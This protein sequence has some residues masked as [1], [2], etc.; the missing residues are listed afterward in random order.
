[1]ENVLNYDNIPISEKI[2][3]SVISY[4]STVYHWITA[5]FFWSFKCYKSPFK[6]FQIFLKRLNKHS[7]PTNMDVINACLKLVIDDPMQISKERPPAIVR[8]SIFDH[9]QSK[10]WLKTRISAI[11]SIALKTRLDTRKR[12]KKKKNAHVRNVFIRKT[13]FSL[14]RNTNHERSYRILNTL[15]EEIYVFLHRSRSIA[16]IRRQGEKW[17]H[18]FAI[19]GHLGR[20]RH[21]IIIVHQLRRHVSIDTTRQLN[22]ICPRVIDFDDLVWDINVM[23]IVNHLTRSSYSTLRERWTWTRPIIRVVFQCLLL[24]F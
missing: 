1:M 9:R 19:L 23:S 16:R 12:L 11:V 22:G 4:S 14:F 6:Y 10:H 24:L 15:F 8:L 3:F 2:N 13:N 18:K 7:T 17:Y 5:S 21:T 20:R